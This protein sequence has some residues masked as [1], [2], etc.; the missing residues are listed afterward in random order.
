MSYKDDYERL[1]RLY[2]L[3]GLIPVLQQEKSTLE[4][5]FNNKKKVNNIVG[6]EK[7]NGCKPLLGL[8]NKIVYHTTAYCEL[9]QCYLLYDDIREK[10]CYHKD[11]KHLTILDENQKKKG[12]K[13]R[14]MKYYDIECETEG[15]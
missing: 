13:N 6:Y 10:S 15:V 1:N 9:K 2:Y 4:N 14:P 5:Y 3:N 12:I 11:C 7:K 8:F